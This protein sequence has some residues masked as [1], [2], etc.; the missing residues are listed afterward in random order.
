MLRFRL[1][2]LFQEGRVEPTFTAKA[3][4]EAGEA[5]MVSYRW[6]WMENGWKMDGK[7]MENEK[8][9]HFLRTWSFLSVV[10]NFKSSDK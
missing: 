10:I 7:W 9:I 3:S 8:G 4:D 1:V 2:K 6:Q 5:M